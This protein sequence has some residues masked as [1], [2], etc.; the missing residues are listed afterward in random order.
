MKTQ[1]R[2]P[3]PATY[4]Q[5]INNINYQIKNYKY[6][7]IFLVTEEKNYLDKLKK[8]Y[9]KDLLCYNNSFRSNKPNI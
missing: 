3:F 1:E 8:Y 5:I 2:H 6:D 4:K 9:S 7:K